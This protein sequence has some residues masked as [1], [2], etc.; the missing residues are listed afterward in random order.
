ML[1]DTSTK[2][3]RKLGVTTQKSARGAAE[4]RRRAPSRKQRGNPGERPAPRALCCAARRDASS[5]PPQSVHRGG[6][7][8]RGGGGWPEGRAGSSADSP[9]AGRRGAQG[10]LLTL[11]GSRCAPFLRAPPRPG[12]GPRA[13]P[14]RS[15]SS[16][17][18][19]RAIWARWRCCWS[20]GRRRAT[21]P[22]TTST[23]GT[24]AA[25]RCGA[26]T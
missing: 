9:A 13:P 1:I 8:R 6:D 15:S 22:R 7:L 17:P 20:G 2:C 19:G 23:R 5:R 16:P 11:A 12:K 26:A 25:A 10:A 21:S 24:P 4:G 14:G 18:R 3:M